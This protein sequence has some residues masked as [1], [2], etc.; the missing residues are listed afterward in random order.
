MSNAYFE[1][2]LYEGVD[3]TTKG[4]ARG[5]YEACSFVNCDFSNA[6]LSD[7]SFTECSFKSCNLSMVKLQQSTLNDA[8]FSDCK[9][10]GINYEHC[11]EFLFTVDFENCLLNFSIFYK[12]VLK[13]TSFRNCTLQEVDFTES[14]LSGSV[15]DKCDLAGARF[16][17]TILDKVDFRTAFNYTINLQLN[18]AK[19]AQFSLTGL[20]GLL[21]GY[22]IVITP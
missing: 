5:Q 6:D 11:N 21:S 20:P 3:Y 1:E 19:K 14:D 4:I 10:L 2:Q 13:K 22:D 7:I 18:K 16:E 15:F 12:R 17:N 9:M 8:K